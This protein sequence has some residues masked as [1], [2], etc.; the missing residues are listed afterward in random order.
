MVTWAV[1]LL[2]LTAATMLWAVAPSGA[3]GAGTAQ[4]TVTF[5]APYDTPVSIDLPLVNR[6][7]TAE[8]VDLFLE[9]LPFIDTV[10]ASDIV[11]P[12]AKKDVT[13]SGRTPKLPP[14]V[15]GPGQRIQDLNLTTT[16]TGTL[17]YAYGGRP[18]EPACL[19]KVDKWD[20]VI[21]VSPGPPAAPPPPPPAKP[22]P[23]KLL[24]SDPCTTWWLTST[25]PRAATEAMCVDKIRELARAYRDRVLA[26]LAARDPAQ[27]AWLPSGAQIATMNISDLLFMRERAAF[28]VR[29]AK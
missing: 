12:G 23:Q 1:R 18:G 21:K 9:G 5:E 16:Y 14:F 3:Q 17:I 22:E 8:P 28:V 20:V 2:A 24:T 25:R 29:G 4:G 26:P 6:C 10:P 15:L 13:A 11:P 19:P 27:W 7:P